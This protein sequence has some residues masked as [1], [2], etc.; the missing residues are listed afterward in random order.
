MKML[1]LIHKD[2]GLC[3]QQVIHGCDSVEKIKYKWKKR[4]GKKYA[5]CVIEFFSDEPKIEFEIYNNLTGDTYKSKHEAKLA[6]GLTIG[7][8]NKQIGRQLRYNSEYY[9]EMRQ[10][11]S[12]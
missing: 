12:Q 9:L 10:K 5:E 1:K 8:I 4:Y 7:H 6:T 2:L 11:V 3:A